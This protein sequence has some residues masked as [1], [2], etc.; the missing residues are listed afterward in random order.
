M[1]NRVFFIILLFLGLSIVHL[2]KVKN[3]VKKAYTGIFLLIGIVLVALGAY[4]LLTS[5]LH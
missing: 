1:N 2:A 3:G 4:G 5:F